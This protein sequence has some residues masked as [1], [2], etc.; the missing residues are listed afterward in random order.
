MD[1]LI[2]KKHQ[3][4][5]SLGQHFLTDDKIAQ[6]IVDSLSYS[7]DYGSIIEIGPGTGQLT[8]FLT[9]NQEH[10]LYL[11]E[12]DND[13]VHKLKLMYPEVEIINKS[14]LDLSLPLLANNLPIA[15][16]GNLPYNVSSSILFKNFDN[17]ELINEMVFMLQKEVA[18]RIAADHGNK[19]YGILSVLLKAFYEIEYL[20]EVPPEVFIPIPKVYSA[21]IRLKR[22]Q[23][24]KLE[25]DKDL[26]TKVV[27]LSFQQRR[28][29][30]KNSLKC[31]NLEEGVIADFANQR[32]EQ[33]AVAAFIEM[34][35]K[36]E[37]YYKSL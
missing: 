28:K 34:T 12:I 9:K 14:Y 20:F 7:K 36:I 18:Q 23:M 24:I 10:K 25:C 6:K 8:K 15:I 16:I 4:K 19:Q 26:F 32:P 31:L 30:I 29:K 11:V 2:Q 1:P 27:K 35:K 17:A 13:L 5:K 22:K 3:P 33:L 21:V 37:H